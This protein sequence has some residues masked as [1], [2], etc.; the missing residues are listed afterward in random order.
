MIRGVGGGRLAAIAVV[1]A[2]VGCSDD[3]A[4][5]APGPEIAEVLTASESY[6]PSDRQVFCRA[7]QNA[8]FAGLSDQA[9]SNSVCVLSSLAVDAVAKESDAGSHVCI[10]ATR[11]VLQEFQN[12]FPGADAKQVLE[13]CG[14]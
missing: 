8:G 3:R 5:P 11:D 14:R 6:T 7:A 9:I 12:R 4:P 13:G 1:A 10:A 2:L